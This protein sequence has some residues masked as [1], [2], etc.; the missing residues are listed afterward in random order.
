MKL[1][2]RLSALW[3]DADHPFLIHKSGEIRFSD[4]AAAPAADLSAVKPGDV[5][6]LIGDF[7]PVSILTLLRLMDMGALAVPLTE[8]TRRDHDYFLDAALADA[9]IENGEVRRRAHGGRHDLIE[10]LRAE[11]G[12]GLVLFSTGT[13][14]EPKAI[15]HN[16]GPLLSRFSAL[17]P[18]MRRTFNFLLFDHMGG[19]NTLFHT[20]FIKGAVIAPEERTVESVLETCA[21]HKVETLPTTPT[22]LRMMLTSGAVPDRIPKSLK[23]ITYGAERMDQPTLDEFCRLLPDIDFRQTFGMSELGVIPVKS[24]ARD[25]LFIKISGEGVET[26]IIDDVLHIRSAFRMMGYLN[27]P[28]PFDGDGWL[29]TG[30]IVETEGD[31][32]KITGRT[33]DVINVGGLKF[34]ASE[35]ERAALEHPQAALV[36]ACARDNPFTGQ[37][38]ELTVQPAGEDAFDKDAFLAFLRE[39][40]QPHMVPKRVRIENVAVGHRFKKS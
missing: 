13:T 5:V 23:V 39:R 25:S 20:L 6:A 3:A 30:D 17:R 19:L 32:F 21:A 40:L 36:K 1:L 35:V 33:G 15:L 38:V 7:D 26:R 12:G 27:A 8:A 24:K 31:Y 9:V 14:S 11:G 37:H 16:L 28:Q 18:I 4:I 34:M 22:F 10:T 2:E 29:N